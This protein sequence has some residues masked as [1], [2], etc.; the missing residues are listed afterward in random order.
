MPSLCARAEDV[1]MARLQT[2][3]RV[4]IFCKFLVFIN[5]FSVAAM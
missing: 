5:L 1:D 3:I 4:S 2:L